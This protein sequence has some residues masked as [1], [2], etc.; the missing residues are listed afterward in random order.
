MHGP[1][2]HRLASA[3]LPLGGGPRAEGG[4]R[5]C[6]ARALLSR[7]PVDA[8]IDTNQASHDWLAITESILNTDYIWNVF[9][10][11]LGE[12]IREQITKKTKQ[13]PLDLV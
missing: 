7:G 13:I 9:H 10:E 8:D 3:A 6:V 2:A 4:R 5:S 11:E 1:R 12:A